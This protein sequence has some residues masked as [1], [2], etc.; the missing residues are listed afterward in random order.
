MFYDHYYLD[1]QPNC[2]KRSLEQ[3]ELLSIKSLL[4]HTRA[5]YLATRQEAFEL[6]KRHSDWFMITR[7]VHLALRYK[8]RLQRAASYVRSSGGLEVLCQITDIEHTD[9]LP[10]IRQA[11]HLSRFDLVKVADPDGT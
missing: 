9:R 4:Y 2:N 7:T 10:V 1:T 6:K 3:R 5:L 8:N 11:E